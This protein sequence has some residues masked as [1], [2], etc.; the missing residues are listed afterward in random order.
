[1]AFVKR[2][3]IFLTAV[4]AAGLLFSGLAFS[5]ILF[6]PSPA[7]FALTNFSMTANKDV[8]ARLDGFQQVPSI[9]S[10]GKGTFEAKISKDSTTISYTLTYT[11]LSSAVTMAHIHFGQSGVNGGIMVWLCGGVKPACPASGTVTGTITAADIVAIPAQGIAAG[12]FAGAVRAI[13][14]GNT[15][16]NVHTSNFPSGEIRGQIPGKGD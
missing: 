14:S 8:Q 2:R 13:E 12:D 16:V 10:D 4:I 15:Y 11:G 7:A 1:M 3:L 9:L 6:G 5:F